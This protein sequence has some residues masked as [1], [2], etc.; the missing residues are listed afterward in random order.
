M[1]TTLKHRFDSLVPDDGDPDIVGP[2]EWDD[3]HISDHAFVV[4]GSIPT[5]LTGA[6]QLTNS[7]L[8][9]LT[10]AGAGSTVTLG[11]SSAAV[12]SAVQAAGAAL[13][14][15][16]DTNVTLTLGGTPGTA[17]LQATSMTLGWTGFLGL[18][19]GGTHADLSA[20]GGTGQYLKQASVGADITVGTIAAGD[21]P[22]SFSGF[23]NPS[24][25]IGLSAVNGS[26]TTAMR[27]DAAPALSQT[28][29]PTWTGLHKWNATLGVTPDD[30]AAGILL[31]TAGTAAAGAQQISPSLHFRGS[32]W[33][34]TATAGAQVV[35]FRNYLLP[36]QGTTAS[37]IA[38]VWE[39]GVNGT[40]ETA[41]YYQYA[42]HGPFGLNGYL[43]VNSF[44]NATTGFQVGGL[45]PS[46][47]VLRGQ[48]TYFASDVLQVT[49]DTNVTM[50]LGG[51]PTV[52]LLAATSLT[53][54]WTGTLAIARGGTGSATPFANPS[55]SLGLAAVNGT[56][57]TFMRSDAAPALSQA[58]APTWSNV[59]IFAPGSGNYGL[60]FNGARQWGLAVLTGNGD[61]VF[62]DISGAT[63]FVNF[64][65][66]GAGA[67]FNGY[68]AVGYNG[69]A[70]TN[71]TRGD[72]TVSRIRV[73]ADAA[74]TSGYVVDVSGAGQFDQ[75]NTQATYIE[76]VALT[77][78]QASDASHTVQQSPSLR[79]TAHVWN[80]AVTAADNSFD[81][82]ETLI[83]TSAVVPSAK[84][85][86]RWSNNGGAFV[87]KMSLS[88]IGILD[89][90]T[91]YRIGGAAASGNFLRGNGTNFVSASIT[92]GDLPGSF[93]GFANPSASVGLAA[94]NGAAT[95]AMRSDA[96]PALSQAINPT[97]TSTHNWTRSVTG[98]YWQT[99][100][101]T[102]ATAV[103]WGFANNAGPT[104]SIDEVGVAQRLVIYGSAA[105][106]GGGIAVVNWLRAGSGAAPTNVT[107]GDFTAARGVF[108]GNIAFLTNETLLNVGGYFHTTFNSGTR[109]A[110][111]TTNGGL[112]VGWNYSVGNAE[113][114][115]WN[116]YDNA[117]LSFTFSQKTGASTHTDLFKLSTAGAL[118]S[119]YLKVGSTT[120]VPT[121]TT[122]GDFTT[123]RGFITNLSV[124][125]QTVASGAGADLLILA[126]GTRSTL[127]LGDDTAN[128][129]Q[130]IEMQ[131]RYTGASGDGRWM[132][133]S[134]QIEFYFYSLSAPGYIWRAFPT[135]EMGFGGQVPVANVA[136][137]LPNKTYEFKFGNSLPAVG[138][139]VPH[140]VVPVQDASGN[141][142]YIPLYNGYTTP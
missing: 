121:N 127:K 62:D 95:T 40:Y 68:L 76:G 27:S 100:A 134:T 115:I 22:G 102:A 122:A 5:N 132:F 61:L 78:K 72:S 56:A 55:A 10:D 101:S 59:H 63:R 26:A 87:E 37:D 108:G 8:L 85:T 4:L 129:Y 90:A 98:V 25:S 3:D 31:A 94:V 50:T 89:L 107:A 97:W 123:T 20:T 54:G 111:D 23:A 47:N 74:M 64:A 13:T 109:P 113:V 49:D 133:E 131:S 15:V 99:W 136:F 19:R 70:P 6:R 14:R 38:L 80:T 88:D 52:A 16:N 119:A 1:V 86:W 142:C 65:A 120:V 93:S 57:T 130:R 36:V 28:I 33:K 17:L 92:A 42:N 104:M 106:S 114:G 73:G 41:M 110:S 112:A 21:L 118:F 128:G 9:S 71:V 32:G 83:P 67:M 124:G 141:L 105:A 45:A 126:S 48:G 11:V 58:I 117:G 125:T 53:L 35:D 18:T 69:T 39:A 91:G 43:N 12:V 82:R 30:T 75:S 29:A 137:S 135:G 96:A 46:G 51:S 84:M 7:G 34:T 139:S 81:M 2:D 44:V 66:S 79:F 116:I 60:K 138:F 103:T 140:A 24:A 77:N